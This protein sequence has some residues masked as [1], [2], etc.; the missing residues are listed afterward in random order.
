MNRSEGVN[1][2][3]AEHVTMNLGG[4][5]DCVCLVTISRPEKK[6][7]LSASLRHELTT[8]MRAAAADPRCRVTVL[9]AEGDVFSA[10][11][12]L[13]EFDTLDED[14]IWSTADELHRAMLAHPLPLIAALDGPAYAGGADLAV[15][16]DLRVGSRRA[17]I[18][19]PERQR[20]PVMLGPL[21]EIVG[22]P[23]A[24]ELAL[25][26]RAVA[27]DEALH[28][29]LL[30]ELVES[31]APRAARSRALALGAEI[32]RT[33]RDLLVAMKKKIIQTRS[34]DDSLTTLEL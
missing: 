7:A 8:A 29:G 23:T 16:A 4:E 18:A 34:F 25:T 12:D 22:R 17:V 3:T 20:Y 5:A 24:H 2:S 11:F 9:A 32:A 26:G 21:A 30:N 31:D 19:H 27:A 33:P 1:G 14:I 6:N 13:A 10:G 15:L 28:L